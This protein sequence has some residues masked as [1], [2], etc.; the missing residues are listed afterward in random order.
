MGVQALQR[1]IGPGD[2]VEVAA[3]REVALRQLEVKARLS[4]AVFGL[5]RQHMRMDRGA[6][7]FERREA[8]SK[9]DHPVVVKSPEN[10]PSCM[11]CGHHGCRRHD[12]EIAELPCLALQIFDGV[13]LGFA[14]DFANDVM[15]TA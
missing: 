3:E 4:V 15:L 9:A 13:I 7:A 10:A 1:I 2:L 5:D 12:V 11:C 14:P 6:T 8:V